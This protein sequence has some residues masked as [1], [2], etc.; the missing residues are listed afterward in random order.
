MKPYEI[1][2]A[3]E[4]LRDLFS[5]LNF[6]KGESYVSFFSDWISLVGPDLACHVHPVDIRHEAL[7]VEVDH[8]GWMQLF[9]LQ[10]GRILKKI[11]KK[12]PSLPIRSIQ[13]RLS[14]LSKEEQISPKAPE[15]NP[16]ESRTVQI[17]RR[18]QESVEKQFTVSSIKNERLRIVLERLEKQIRQHNAG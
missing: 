15:P 12:H 18:V 17:P 4:I 16:L 7:L 11:Q 10:E 3:G 1:E 6:Q 2:K 8:P 14:K 13:M 9:Q 5:H